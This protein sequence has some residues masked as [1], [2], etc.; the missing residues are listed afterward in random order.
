[1]TEAASTSAAEDAAEQIDRSPPIGVFLS[2]ESFFKAAQHLQRACETG[3]LCL[4]F[5]TPI[6]YLYCH[7]LELILKAFL[8]AKGMPAHRLASR[9][10][11]H[12]LGSGLCQ[13]PE[14]AADVER[15]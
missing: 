5:D 8:R 10:F 6:Y 4:R 7:A 12:A 13:A 14:I 11:G 2:G 3:E 1:M 15:R 9:K